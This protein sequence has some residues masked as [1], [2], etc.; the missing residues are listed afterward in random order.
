MSRQ[1]R[2]STSST[3]GATP[4]RDEEY[5]T[6][7]F[8]SV[9]GTDEAVE[10]TGWDELVGPTSQR[11]A[12]AS[13]RQDDV[14]QRDVTA[15]DDERPT[16]VFGA[17]REEPPE[18]STVAEQLFGGSAVPEDD[19]TAVFARYRDTDPDPRDTTGAP[20]AHPAPPDE[21]HTEQF[22]AYRDRAHDEP[23]QTPAGGSHSWSGPSVP[24]VSVP[25]PM[26]PPI[27]PIPPIPTGLGRP[28]VTKD[29]AAPDRTGAPEAPRTS[30]GKRALREQPTADAQQAADEG[31]RTPEGQHALDEQR[32]SGG[33]GVQPEGQAGPDGLDLKPGDEPAAEPVLDK[34]A[35]KRLAREQQQAAK[36][37]AK[38]EKAA[39]AQAA[40]DAK[41]AAEKAAKDAK[42]AAKAAKKA[43]RGRGATEASAG[44]AEAAA[45]TEA[46]AT[47]VAATEAAATE[48]A[49]A[50]GTSATPSEAGAEPREPAATTPDGE[51]EGAASAAQPDSAQ[52]VG[53]TPAV[54]VAAAPVVQRRKAPVL[55]VLLLLFIAVASGAAAWLFQQQAVTASKQRPSSNI[56]LLDKSATSDVVAQ[57]S[58]AVEAIYSYDSASLDQSESLALSQITGSYVS[59]FKDNFAAVR[60][61][62]PQQRASL[63]SKVAAAGVITLTERRASLLVMLDQVG[64]RGDNAP[65][66]NSAV[67]LSVTAQ[68][69]DGQW[70]VSDISQR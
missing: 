7:T 18:P 38:A 11:P 9:V 23:P 58:K 16:Q 12:A 50:E 32:V 51:A 24:P 2:T 33:A 52:A 4:G 53:T 44:A 43:G 37:T 14:P 49:A 22:A 6:D 3:G 45:A 54:A 8:D 46:A 28:G 29:S 27:P 63:S 15:E 62:P 30:G 68:R 39:A 5:P 65:P 35:A 31:Q 40:K 36:D 42:L 20:A 48:V 57:V 66:V 47:E 26:T 70:K 41:A 34:K 69:V 25:V 1:R 60:A 61:L 67:R 10:D 19:D 59:E 64:R 17:I 21:V 56:A 13:Y 55:V